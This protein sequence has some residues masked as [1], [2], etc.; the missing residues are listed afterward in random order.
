[1]SLPHFEGIP[2]T[3]VTLRTSKPDAMQSLGHGILP[4]HL[5]NHSDRHAMSRRDCSRHDKH[6]KSDAFAYKPR[7]SLRSTP[8][9]DQSQGCAAMA[10]QCVTRSETAVARQS[11]I[12]ASA[13]AVSGDGGINRRRKVFNGLHER[14][15]HSRE[16]IRCRTVEGRNFV[17]VGTGGKKF[18]IPGDDQRLAMVFEF[19]DRRGQRPHARLG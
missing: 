18:C 2:P 10:K 19:A 12:Q 11:Q 16:F 8:T 15:A 6:L 9:G 3:M 5:I 7:K 1:M 13:H 4:Y 17:E 14:L